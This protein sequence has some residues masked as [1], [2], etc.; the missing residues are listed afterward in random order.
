MIKCFSKESMPW[1]INN[2]LFFNKM[3]NMHYLSR[4]NQNA[5]KD[6]EATFQRV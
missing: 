4:N 3:F 5:E 1:E 2:A 6:L